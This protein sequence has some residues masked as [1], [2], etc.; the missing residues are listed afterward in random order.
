M[1]NPNQN[2]F[3][4]QENQPQDNTDN[5]PAL[6]MPR[7]DRQRDMGSGLNAG[8]APGTASADSYQYQGE[9]SVGPGSDPHA[10]AG[11]GTGIDTGQYR[12]SDNGTST[13]A[14]ASPE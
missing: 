10:G 9:Q 11:N 6:D 14:K 5:Q 13:D 1:N 7:V 3:Q 2:P 8:T 4:E 12:G